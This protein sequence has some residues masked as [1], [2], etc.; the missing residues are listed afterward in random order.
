MAHTKKGQ[1][2][3]WRLADACLTH[4]MVELIDVGGELFLEGC[5]SLSSDFYLNHL[6][7]LLSENK[8]SRSLVLEIALLRPA[9]YF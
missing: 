5:P 6:M 4:I 9:M 7:H 1:D 2:I 8:K 3:L